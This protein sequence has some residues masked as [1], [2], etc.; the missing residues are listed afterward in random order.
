MPRPPRGEADRGLAGLCGISR[1][2]LEHV[3]VYV[4][5]YGGQGPK[6]VMFA[7]P[8]PWFGLS[9]DTAEELHLFAAELGRL[10]KERG[11]KLP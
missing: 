7:W 11:I 9:A 6:P 5:K 2:R 3:T 10:A 4:Y 8:L 1:P